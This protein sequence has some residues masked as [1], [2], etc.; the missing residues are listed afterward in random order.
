MQDTHYGATNLSITSVFIF[1]Y[2]QTVLSNILPGQPGVHPAKRRVAHYGLSGQEP[3]S[4]TVLQS[5]DWVF[6]RSSSCVAA[7]A[8]NGPCEAGILRGRSLPWRA[9]PQPARSAEAPVGRHY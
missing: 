3:V 1:E 6:K 2:Y 8:L 9:S 5:A 7:C 4:V